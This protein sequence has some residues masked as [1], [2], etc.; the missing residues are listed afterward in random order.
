M[1]EPLYSELENPRNLSRASQ[2]FRT[3]GVRLGRA[4]LGEA[5]GIA[6]ACDGVTN[7][8]GGNE[9]AKGPIEYISLNCFDEVDGYFKGIPSPAGLHAATEG[10]SSELDAVKLQRG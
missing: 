8:V 3:K 2:V 5:Y 4:H 7:D 10:T 9:G 1:L 6:L